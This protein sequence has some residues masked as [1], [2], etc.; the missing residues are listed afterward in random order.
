[1]TSLGDA[2]K[3][4]SELVPSIPIYS[5][6]FTIDRDGKVSILL[7]VHCTWYVC[8]TVVERVVEGTNTTLFFVV[9]L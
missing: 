7:Q 8:S 9:V 4:S 2:I 1:M 6:H 5:T 3:S